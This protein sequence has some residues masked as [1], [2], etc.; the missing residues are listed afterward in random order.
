MEINKDKLNGQE[1]LGFIEKYNP[2]YN[3]KDP[4]DIE[5]Y[6]NSRETSI[7]NNIYFCNPT[8]A[9]K[10]TFKKMNFEIMFKDN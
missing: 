4:A 6:K 2:Y 8:K 5:R 3:I 1:K 7:F 10:E 9:F